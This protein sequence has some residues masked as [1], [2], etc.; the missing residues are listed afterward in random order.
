VVEFLLVATGATVDKKKDWLK[1]LQI[2]EKQFAEP[3]G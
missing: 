3:N 2:V 1:G